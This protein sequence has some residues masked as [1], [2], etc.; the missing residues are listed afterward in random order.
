MDLAFA[1]N[2][3][4]SFYQPKW[5]QP[6]VPSRYL[7]VEWTW[8]NYIHYQLQS[9]AWLTN[10]IVWTNVGPQVIGPVHRQSDTNID[11]RQ[12]FYRVVAP[13]VVP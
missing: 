12:R 3:S 13:D 4:Q 2:T 8:D 7:T 11:A 6:P 10:V 1:L 9:T 5:S